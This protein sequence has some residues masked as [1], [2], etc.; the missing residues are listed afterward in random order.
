MTLKASHKVPD[1]KMVELQLEVNSG[2]VGEARIR[3]DFFLEPPEKLK[4][5]E[6]RLRGLET[7]IDK[8][9]IIEELE[10]VDADLIGFSP[11]DVAEAFREA[12]E[13]GK[14]E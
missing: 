2:K 13:G 6:K 5:L 7:G 14:D 4:E 9:K 1:G 10:N 3:G 12:V 8:E 11:E